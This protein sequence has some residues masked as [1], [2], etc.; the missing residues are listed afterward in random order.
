MKNEDPNEI[1][2]RLAVDLTHAKFSPDKQIQEKQMQ[3]GEPQVYSA[4]VNMRNSI[5]QSQWRQVQAFLTFNVIAWP[6]VFGTDPTTEV[7]FAISVVGVVSN[8]LLLQRAVR[9]DDWVALLDVRLKALEESDSGTNSAIRTRFFAD[10]GLIEL[11]AS[12]LA[13]R[14]SFNLICIGALLAW[15]WQ[16]VKYSNVILP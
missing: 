13:S 3:N 16:V 14:K 4:L 10:T 15:V 6:I 11:K 12:W 5:T 8:M 2:A 7:K 9:A 1:L